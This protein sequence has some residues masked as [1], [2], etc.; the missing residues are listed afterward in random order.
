MVEPLYNE[1]LDSLLKI[2][3][4]EP[5]DDD[6]TLAAIYQAV[7]DVRLGLFTRLGKTRALEIQGYALI[8]NPTTDDETTRSTA[9]S[10]EALWTYVL[11]IQRLPVIF[12]DNAASTGDAFNEEPLT[13]DASS[14]HTFIN[15]LKAQLEEALQ[16]ISTD[17]SELNKS[18]KSSLNGPEVPY[19]LSQNHIGLT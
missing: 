5:A 19:L 6:N 9:A 8:D 15:S 10:A 12:M 2:V 7:R 11:L 13:R 4:I 16:A 3:R 1:T 18:F 17:V 14:A